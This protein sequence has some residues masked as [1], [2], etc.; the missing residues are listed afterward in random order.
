M[1]CTGVYHCPSKRRKTATSSPAEPV[2]LRIEA[3]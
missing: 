1:V 3:N 2:T